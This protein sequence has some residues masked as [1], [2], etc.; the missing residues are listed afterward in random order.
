MYTI[1][2]VH[3]TNLRVIMTSLI[4]ARWD[5]KQGS[6]LRVGVFV[7]CCFALTKAEATAH[8][9]LVAIAVQ[10]PL[11][12]AVSNDLFKD[13]TANFI[14][15]S[16][17]PVPDAVSNDVFK[18]N[19]AN[20]VA[21]SLMP[22]P[23]AVSNDFFQDNAANLIATSIM[24]VPAAVSNDL[25]KDN[26]ASLVATSPIPV[27]DIVSNGLFEDNIANHVANS[28][29][30]ES[31]DMTAS[32][33]KNVVMKVVEV[34]TEDDEHAVI[35]DDVLD[36]IN[37]LDDRLPLPNATLLVPLAPA[38]RVP[39]INAIAPYTAENQTNFLVA[40]VSS[41][42]GDIFPNKSTPTSLSPSVPVKQH[43]KTIHTDTQLH[44]KTMSNSNLPAL[45][46]KPPPV[47]V[48]LK[49][50]FQHKSHGVGA[51]AARTMANTGR[52]KKAKPKS[53]IG[54]VHPVKDRSHQILPNVRRVLPGSA[55]VP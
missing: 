13:N 17:M 49:P 11:V 24:P 9:A 44:H 55:V 8:D 45:L 47:P 28:P 20:L 19:A 34:S 37:V 32:E 1:V 27:P 38:S 42:I 48:D 30:P 16:L 6:V 2:G 23:D 41:M 15:A 21:A 36:Y 25:F 4:S 22:V 50:A 33:S 54:D 46:S 10:T 12:D 43:V 26:T 7:L 29:T 53:T 35:K 18:D 3:K 51:T 14:A 52:T 31:K 5:P 40:K 39:D